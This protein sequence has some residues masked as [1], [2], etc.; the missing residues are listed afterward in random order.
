MWKRATDHR[1]GI[2]KRTHITKRIDSSSNLLRYFYIKKGR[3]TLFRKTSSQTLLKSPATNRAKQ[4]EGVAFNL[5][6]PKSE[7]IS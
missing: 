1:N 3:L 7:V 5:L 2:Q 4:L 6:V